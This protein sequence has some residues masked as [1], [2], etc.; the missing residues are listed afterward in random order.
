M[1]TF[2]IAVLISLPL[3]G[4]AAD[5]Q[6]PAT[7]KPVAQG[8]KGDEDQKREKETRARIY[9]NFHKVKKGMTRE[10]V[11]EVLGDPTLSRAEGD[12]S[13]N[14]ENTGMADLETYRIKFK[15]GLV[16]EASSAGLHR[17]PRGGR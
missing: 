16:S 12:L 5:P 7:P 17:G 1:R 3:A 8:A 13:W 10:E 6:P 9:S 11:A 14:F 2:V 15:D 4:W